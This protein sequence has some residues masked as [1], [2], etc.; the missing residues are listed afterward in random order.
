[1]ADE[2]KE[3]P[4]FWEYKTILSNQEIIYV[5]R[6]PSQILKAVAILSIKYVNIPWETNKFVIV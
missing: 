1:M 6:T 4:K 5:S 2:K 3:S